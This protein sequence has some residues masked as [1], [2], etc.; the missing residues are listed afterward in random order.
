M[1]V[2]HW[3]KTDRHNTNKIYEHQVADKYERIHNIT[4]QN[5]KYT[6]IPSWSMTAG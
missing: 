6:P 2:C 1:C 4:L 3:I 5:Y